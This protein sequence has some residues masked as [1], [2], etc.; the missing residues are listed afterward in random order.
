VD[1][2]LPTG[3]VYVTPGP[4]SI[5]GTNYTYVLADG[6]YT[7][8]E[9]RLS[10]MAVI[11]RATLYVPGSADVGGRIVIMRDAS[12]DLY[13]GGASTSISL[14]SVVNESGNAAAFAYY[15]L[16]NNTNVRAHGDFFSGTIYAPGADVTIG[17]GGTDELKMSGA[18]VGRNIR[19][20]GK[21]LLHYDEWLGIGGPAW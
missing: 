14:S 10:W 21:L 7:L 20:N 17:G 3:H 11:G 18:V 12:L 1:A 19:V 9:L 16:P 4:G 5:G 6:H 15:G 2:E 13:V 8:P